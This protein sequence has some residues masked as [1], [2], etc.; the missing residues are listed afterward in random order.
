M[1]FNLHIE[2]HLL[3]IEG[4]NM[5]QEQAR[6]EWDKIFLYLQHILRLGVLI[7]LEQG[8]MSPKDKDVFFA[9]GEP[10]TSIVISC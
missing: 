2:F 8:R 1:A 9:S 7:C 5:L 6:Q 10:A 3:I 4:D